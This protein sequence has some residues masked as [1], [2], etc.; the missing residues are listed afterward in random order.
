MSALVKD[1]F[2]KVPIVWIVNEAGHPYDKIKK[3]RGF[4]NAELRPLTMSSINPLRPDRL[5]FDLAE[6]IVKYTQRDHYVLIS[7][8]PTVNMLAG[9]LWLLQWGE[10]RLIQWN[11]INREYEVTTIELENFRQILK[12]QTAL[13]SEGSS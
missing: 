12:R 9:I 7:G 5:T 10:M 4:E 8:T 13:S 1:K 11:A 2:D 3:K 6:G